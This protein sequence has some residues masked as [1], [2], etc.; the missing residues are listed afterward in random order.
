MISVY[1]F[2]INYIL[3]KYLFYMY[4][5]VFIIIILCELNYKYLCIL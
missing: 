5:Y 1:N 3:C 4:N 2:D